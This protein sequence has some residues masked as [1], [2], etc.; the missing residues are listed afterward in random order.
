MSVILLLVFYIYLLFLF[1]NS[2]IIFLKHINILIYHFSAIVFSFTIY[3]SYFQGGFAGIVME[4]HT[5]LFRCK[6]NSTS[7][8]KFFFLCFSTS[9]PLYYYDQKLH[10]YTWHKQPHKI[11]IIILYIYLFNQIRRKRTAI[12]IFTR[13]FILIQIVTLISVFNTACI[14]NL[15]S[16][17]CHF[18]LS[19]SLQYPYSVGL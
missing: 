15:L 11:L 8:Q 5:G 16:I 18:S 2:F 13:D 14:F 6:F 7:T 10:H 17:P 4:S 9:L 3:S 12:K 1:L 19:S